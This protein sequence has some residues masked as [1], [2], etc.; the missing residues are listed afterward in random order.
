MQQLNRSLT[1]ED[2]S[3]DTGNIGVLSMPPRQCHIFA[4]MSGAVAIYAAPELAQ[5][6]IHLTSPHSVNHRA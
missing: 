5:P 6:T 4:S 1:G 3:A 2:P